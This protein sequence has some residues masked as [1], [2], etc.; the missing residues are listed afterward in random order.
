LKTPG[1]TL[2]A[3]LAG[4]W[5]SN[6]DTLASPRE[7]LDEA[8]GLAARCG[9]AALVWHPRQGDS[10][11]LTAARIAL[12]RQSRQHLALEDMRRQYALDRL[13]NAFVSAG[14]RVLV[15]KGPA[16]ASAYHERFSRPYG[17][18]D[19]I[20][21]PDDRAATGAL[22]AALSDTH[23]SNPALG[24]YQLDGEL[25]FSVDF[26]G[27]LDPQ[28][29]PALPVARVFARAIAGPVPGLLQPCAED[30][31]R[32][33][34]LH[35]L[36]HGGTRPIWLCDIAALIEAAPAT[37]DWNACLGEPGPI[38]EWMLACFG[39]AQHLLDCRLPDAA[40]LHGATAPCWFNHTLTREWEAFDPATRVTNRL[41]LWRHPLR[42]LAA[43]RANAIKTGF[44][45]RRS[46]TL[47]PGRWDR[48]AQAASHLFA[49]FADRRWWQR[50][51]RASGIARN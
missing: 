46:V 50:W 44:M 39:A 28:R 31:L 17:D 30:H 29:Y 8:L 36:R 34:T 3:L 23:A 2:A 10:P 22:I 16:V 43:Y 47:A 33:V 40:A 41:M 13:G 37:M 38:R 27:E 21:H 49:R 14:L 20:A 5:R 24:Q 6:T 4:S 26:H 7:D 18:F 11:D 15:F 12:L 32:M 42:Y 19:L 1:S 9:C 25:G 35:L 48:T 45:Q 51:M